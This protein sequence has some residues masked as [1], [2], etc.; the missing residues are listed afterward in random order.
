MTVTVTL[1]LLRPTRETSSEGSSLVSQSQ[2]HHSSHSHITVVSCSQSQSHYVYG[3]PHGHQV[4]WFR[5][6][7]SYINIVI[8]S[9]KVS[10]NDVTTL[11]YRT[12]YGCISTYGT[13]STCGTSSFNSIFTPKRALNFSC[14]V[15]RTCKEAALYSCVFVHI[16]VYA[17]KNTCTEPTLHLCVCM[18]MHVMYLHRTHVTLVYIYLYMYVYLW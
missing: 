11:F 17:C 1:C 18:C 5:K 2:S 9:F 12:T 13:S 3:G 7:K 16:C 15:W 6:N 14:A 8:I 10:H 4:H